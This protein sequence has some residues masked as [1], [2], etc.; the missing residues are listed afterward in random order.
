MGIFSGVKVVGIACSLIRNKLIAWLIGPAGLGLVI[1]YNSILDLIGQSTRLSIDQSAQR[2]ISQAGTAEAPRTVAVVRRWAVWLGLAGMAATCALSPLLSLWSFDDFSHWRSFCLLSVVPLCL[3]ISACVT[4]ENQGLRRFRAVAVSNILGAV[5]GLVLSVPLIIWLRID[6]IIWIILAYG[7]MSFIGAWLFRPRLG[8]VNVAGNVVFAEGKSFIRLGTRITLATFVNQ[9]F[10]YVFIIFLNTYASTD[11]L[12]IYQAGYTLM[13]SYVGIVFTALWVEYYPRLAA[14]AHSPRR[15]SLAA[16]HEVR[17]TLTLLTPCL[18]LLIILADPVVRIIY[19]ADFL[20][21]IPYIVV[22]CIGVVFRTT[23]WCLAYVILARGDGR[24]YLITEIISNIIGLAVNIAGYLLG[25]FLG[26]GI[27][28]TAW[29]ACYTVIV[30]AVC[31]RR[32]GV[33]YSPRTTPT[34][35]TALALTTLTALLYLLL[36]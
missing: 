17:L 2:D 29:Y 25:G 16:S 27:A 28:Y 22:G 15:L 18:C 20:E 32:Y 10:A 26:L 12:G 5:G 6:S 9:A 4:A 21:V 7:L 19:A 23:S 13:N 1:L 14:M 30:G 34:I 3:T 24:S 31:S 8:K 33:R 36:Y 35:L 11:T